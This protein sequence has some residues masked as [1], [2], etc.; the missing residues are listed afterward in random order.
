MRW[1]VIAIIFA[2]VVVAPCMA[3][4]FPWTGHQDIM[5]YN[6]LSDVAGYRTID[7]VPEQADQVSITTAPI[8]VSSGEVTLGTWLTPPFEETTTIAPGRWIFRTY[9]VA[10]SDSGHT[11]MHFRI[12]NRTETGESTYLFF[13]RAISQDINRGITPAEYNTYYARRNVTTIHPG[14]RLG[15][16]INVSTDSASARTVTL[17]VSGNTN[18]SYVSTGYWLGSTPIT[19]TD[20][21]TAHI[22]NLPVGSSSRDENSQLLLWILGGCILIFLAWRLLCRR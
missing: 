2:A 14:D 4:E 17:E 1:F 16:Q 6:A 12:F 21:P 22:P 19:P 7:H 10:S 11:L 13:G 8:T 9:A 18:A 20:A 5:F 15:I 3:T